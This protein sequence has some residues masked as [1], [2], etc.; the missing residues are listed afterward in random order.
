M[1]HNFEQ[2]KECTGITTRPNLRFY[3]VHSSVNILGKF[4]TNYNSLKFSTIDWGLLIVVQLQWHKE[5]LSPDLQE[6]EM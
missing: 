3:T 4:L 5:F 2:I 1:P 6:R